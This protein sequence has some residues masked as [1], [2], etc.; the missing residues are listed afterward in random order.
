MPSE[1]SMI[2]LHYLAT[3]LFLLACVM[4]TQNLCATK[5]AIV[6]G[7]SAGMGRK[8]A[9]L[10]SQEGYELGLVARRLPLLE[11]LQDELPG[12]SYIKQ[13]DVT[14]YNAREKLQELIDEMAGLDLIVISISA[15]LDNRTTAWTKLERTLNVDAKGFIAMADVAMHYFKQQNHGHLVGISSTSGQRGS[16]LNPVYSGAKACI[17]YYMEGLR[18]QMVRDNINVY[19]SDVVAGFV[20]V[21]HSPLGQ[22]PDAYWEITVQEAGQCIL[23]G[24]KKKKKIIYVPSKIWIVSYALKYL[25]DFIFQRFFNWL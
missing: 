2:F 17:S 13:I 23:D 19:I 10:L 5:K 4:C 12:V 16:P 1:T 24:I 3:Y 20:A 22:D 9:K 8:V 14:Q 15:Y 18:N 25:P 11:S 6:I 21:E 7:A